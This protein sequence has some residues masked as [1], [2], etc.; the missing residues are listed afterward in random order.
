M[1]VWLN[2][3]GSLSWKSRWEE[4]KGLE[5]GYGDGA[6]FRKVLCM[7]C[8]NTEASGVLLVLPLGLSP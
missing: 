6:A 2:P 1:H 4:S 5:A 7:A 3:G 8:S